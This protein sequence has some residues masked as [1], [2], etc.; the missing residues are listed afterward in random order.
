MKEKEIKKLLDKFNED[1]CTGEELADLQA[2][3]QEL[4]HPQD[5]AQPV[6][7]LKQAL[8]QK[9]Q[10]QTINQPRIARLNT[11]WLKIAALFLI[12]LFAGIWGYRMF[13]DSK[14]ADVIACQ[15]IT[16]PKGQIKQI[17][18]PDSTFVQLNAGSTISFPIKFSA[19]TREV[20]L[21]N[22]EAFLK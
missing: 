20:T 15:I 6:G 18:L 8:W 4:S 10:K 17:L 12:T 3:M 7:H 2:L 19:A 13:A 11:S 16:A 14:T 21:L 1:K 22:G 5:T 9:I